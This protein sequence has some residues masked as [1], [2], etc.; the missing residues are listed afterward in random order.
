MPKWIHDR[1]SH[2]EAKNPDMPRSMA[3]AIATQQAH[4]IKKSSKDYGTE[5]GLEIARKSNDKTADL[6]GLSKR[7]SFFRAVS[8]VTPIVNEELDE[9]TR[10]LIREELSKMNAQLSFQKPSGK[11]K[12]AVL[13]P[14]LESFSDEVEKIA[15]LVSGVRAPATMSTIR[16]TIPRNTLKT[17]TPKYTQINPPSM[18]SPAQLHQPILGPPSVRG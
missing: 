9:R 12:I 18:G 8:A 6:G 15:N 17:T 7:A 11:S 16:S 3:F 13:L 4:T 2:I 1:A 14:F 5:E 10:H